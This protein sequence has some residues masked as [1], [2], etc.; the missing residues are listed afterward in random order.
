LSRRPAGALAGI[1]MIFLIAASAA[2]AAAPVRD[3][4]LSS[5]S[6]ASASISANASANNYPINDGSGATI[7]VS[8]TSACQTVCTDPDPQRIANFIGTLIH[9]AEVE[10]LTVQLD[11]P[12]QLE[13]DCG[14]GAEACYY[15]EESKVVLSGNDTPD[16][17][18]A[19]REFIL[20]HEYG[21]HV[22]RHRMNPAPFPPAV[23][24]GTAHWAS[25]ENVCRQN[26]A[27]ALFPG[28]E[29]DHYFQDPG[30]AFAE[31]FAHYRFSDAQ[32]RWRWLSSLKPDAGSFR[33][34]REDTLNP[35]RGRTRLLLAGHLPSRRHGAIVKSFRTPLDGIVS[36]RPRGRPAHRYKLSIRNPTGRLLRTSHHGLSRRDHLDF[37]VCGQSRLR[38]V[39][40]SARRSGG[41]FRLQ[42]QRP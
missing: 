40:R 36:V 20:A 10:Q 6:V 17:E 18:G 4:V 1:A 8:V 7:V 33:A 16:S 41:A 3:A 37:T 11:T 12:F 32:V 39:I 28:N 38:A 42:I 23:D 19:S 34:I 13:F 14:F 24:W 21:H 31:A 30:E 27:G 2:Q 26:R 25:Y 5:Q 22:A 35:W 9:G 15:T 29:G